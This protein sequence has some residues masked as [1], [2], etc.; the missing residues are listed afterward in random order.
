[1]TGRGNIIDT[2]CE[3]SEGSASYSLRRNNSVDMH[4][5]KLEKDRQRKSKKRRTESVS[6]RDKRLRANC[7]YMARVIKKETTNERN[8][9]LRRNRDR[10][11]R[12]RA[13]NK[14][15]ADCVRTQ[16]IEDQCSSAEVRKNMSGVFIGRNRSKRLLRTH[17]SITRQKTSRRRRSPALK[18]SNDFGGSLR[19]RSVRFET[20]LTKTNGG[21]RTKETFLSC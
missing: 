1:M 16:C 17:H 19:R 21:W 12:I 8:I 11:A 9:L 4:E 7:D 18:K 6:E 14:R 5:K 10:Q 15:N 3:L 13:V 2:D 20:E